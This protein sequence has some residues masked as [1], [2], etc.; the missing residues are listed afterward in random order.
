MLGGGGGVGRPP[1]L[2]FL[3]SSKY[4]ALIIKISCDFSKI[5]FADMLLPY[6]KI[7]FHFP[8]AYVFYLIP[9]SIICLFNFFMTGSALNL[10]L[11]SVVRHDE[12]E[13][14]K[15]GILHDGGGGGTR[16]LRF[17]TWIHK[18]LD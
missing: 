7:A 2:Y 6:N 15:H 14:V 1:L 5:Y 4:V 3:P 12:L 8:F 17:W 13:N 11:K 16:S 9:K 10:A 18:V